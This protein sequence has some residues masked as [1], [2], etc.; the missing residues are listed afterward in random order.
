M[1]HFL[2]GLILAVLATPAVSADYAGYA[3]PPPAYG[4]HH[5][6]LPECTDGNVLSRVTEKFA[7][8]DAH[9]TLTGLRIAG[10][11]DIM[12]TSLTA[13][14]P[15]LINRR[16]CAATAWMSDGSQSEVVYLIE[17]PKLGT[18]SIGWHVE[19]CVPGFDVYRV[20]D[21]WCRSIRQ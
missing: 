10:Y 17:S 3:P 5:A 13:G 21:A 11:D 15:S 2:G 8:Q 14:G 9:L 18:F 7:Y 6:V 20:Y 4:H 16:Y 12:E 1:R 19:S